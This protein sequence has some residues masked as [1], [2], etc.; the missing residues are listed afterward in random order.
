[1]QASQFIVLH[2]PSAAVNRNPDACKSGYSIWRD[3]LDNFGKSGRNDKLSLEVYAHHPIPA[4][5]TRGIYQWYGA[6]VSL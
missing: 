5:I 3:P 4:F 1:M 6:Y 2:I